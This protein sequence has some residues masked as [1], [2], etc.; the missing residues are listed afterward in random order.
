MLATARPYYTLMILS[1]SLSVCLNFLARIYHN[2]TTKT[3]LIFCAC[4]LDL[5]RYLGH[6]LAA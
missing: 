4:C 5:W 6:V 3:H 1:P 2:R